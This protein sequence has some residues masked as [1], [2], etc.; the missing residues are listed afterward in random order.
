MIASVSAALLVSF[1]GPQI[2]DTFA[3]LSMAEGS[4]QFRP[5]SGD[6]ASNGGNV[7]ARSAEAQPVVITP[8]LIALARKR[9]DLTL[10]DY[11]NTRFMDVRAYRSE[12][13]TLI[14]FCGKVNGPNAFGAPTG[15]R[16]F[17]LLPTM[18]S[19]LALIT[20]V[21]VPCAS[22]MVP[23]DA[24]DYSDALTAE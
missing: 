17:Q 7:L 6:D 16:D 15:W 3:S 19:S 10:R 13:S 14:A 20:D 21:R 24:V 1:T 12:T 9:L 18:D 22:R 2:D 23:V 11:P 8:D 4:A 5:V